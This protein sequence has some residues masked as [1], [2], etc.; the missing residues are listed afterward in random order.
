LTEDVTYAKGRHMANTQSAKG[1]TDRGGIIP[2]NGT[3]F[4]RDIIAT[5]GPSRAAIVADV[6]PEAA[7]LA[8]TLGWQKTIRFVVAGVLLFGGF[9]LSLHYATK[10]MTHEGTNPWVE[11]GKLVCIALGISVPSS[12]PVYWAAIKIRVYFK[13]HEGRSARLEASID[14]GRQSSGVDQDGST[15]YDP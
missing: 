12:I 6:P 3:V 10:I 14:R 5:E 13:N 11:F 8:K 15:P 7:A 9:W 2:S 1:S 4:P